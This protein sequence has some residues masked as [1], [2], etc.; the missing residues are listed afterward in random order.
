MPED[1]RR[2]LFA[3]HRDYLQAAFDQMSRDHGDVLEYLHEVVGVDAIMRS[4]V[5]AELLSAE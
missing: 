2:V 4:K 1:I 5:Q 3:A